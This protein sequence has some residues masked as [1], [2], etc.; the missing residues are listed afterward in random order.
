M[1]DQ[2]DR[3]EQD[4][5]N[6][7]EI[8]KILEDVFKSMNFSGSNDPQKTAAAPQKTA[9]APQKTATAPQKTAT[10]PQKT[11]AAP[12]K[13]ALAPEKTAAAPE[14][15]AK[16]QEKASPGSQ[17]PKQGILPPGQIIT[18]G[19]R[20]LTIRRHLSSGGEGE[21]YL[22]TDSRKEYT[23]KLFHPGCRT[24]SKIL[25]PL[26]Q[27]NGKGFIADII[28]FSEDYELT[29][30]IPGGDAASAS[31]KGNAQAILAI[32]VKTAAAL[33][34]LHKLN[35]L[36]KDIKPANILIKNTTTWD[37]VLCD[38]GISELL[39]IDG[40]CTTVQGRTPIYA[41][42][43]IYTATVTLPSGVFVELSTKSDFYS[44]G[45]SILS[46]W[47]GEKAFR[48]QESQMAMD[49]VKG[50]IQVPSDMP[51]PLARI[52]RGL[53]IKNPAKRWDYPEIERTLNGE[54]VPVEEDEIIED[55]NITFSAS[56]HLVA[57]SPEELADCMIEDPDLAKKY[58]YRGQLEKW[59]KP[60]PE[61]VLEM[62]EITEKRY[63]KDQDTGMMA[64]IYTLN[65][66]LPIKLEGVSRKD[67]KPL[68]RTVFSFKDV[69]NFCNDAIP[70]KESWN[71]L[72]SDIFLE[73]VRSK[74]KS[75]ADKLP[76]SKD[77][78]EV[79][80][81][82]VQMLDPLS[83]LNLI[84]DPSDGLYAMT[85]ESL[86]RL[87]NEIYSVVWSKYHGDLNKM[88]EDYINDDR[89][90]RIMPVT[91]FCVAASIQHPDY[92]TYLGDALRTKGERFTSQ[93]SW[94]KYCTDY[95][96]ADNK[97][98][99]G[100]KDEY[101]R[102]QAAWMKIIKGFGYTP[103]YKFAGSGKTVTTVSELFRQPKSTIRNAYENHGLA[104]WLAVQHHENPNADLSKQFA[105]ERLLKDYLED[106]RRIDDK[107]TY[108]TRFDRARNQV[109]SMVSSARSRIR[110]LNTS[111]T[112]QLVCTVL[113]AIIP[114]IILVIMLIMAIVQY[115]L[116]DTSGLA[117]QKFFWPVG[118]LV[119]AIV[120][121]T[122]DDSNGCIVPV[123]AGAIVAAALSFVVWL[124]GKFILYIFLAVVLGLGGYLSWKIL[125][126]GKSSQ[127]ARKLSK[128]GFDELV[129]EPLYYAFSDEY[130]FDSSLSLELDET[131]LNGWKADLKKR[132]I[133]VI[134]F[135]AS[136]WVLVG[137]STFVPNSWMHDKVAV[138]VIEQV[139]AP[140]MEQAAGK[141]V[142]KENNDLIKAQSLNPGDKGEEVR[143]LQKFLISTG[144]LKSAADGEYGANTRLAVRT[145]QRANGIKVTGKADKKT[146]RKIN[147]LAA[148]EG[149]TAK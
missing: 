121:F 32:A 76:A 8:G 34:R 102:A 38:F 89:S 115:P 14:K 99:A 64:A 23:L 77:D 27:L 105:Y 141:A 107:N 43:E 97:K 53:L 13:T 25:S 7:E 45:M 91:V 42:P 73:W 109:D 120:F 122:D 135:I 112:L 48:S 118:L 1:A 129:L 85:G 149:K 101:Y 59:L 68:S 86:G 46:M 41:A 128:P 98:K 19:S 24:R 60:Y 147:E 69:G 75:L 35:I 44:L 55:L 113:F 136:V 9:T 10:A 87:L 140:M 138:P 65:P 33:D 83:D 11:A 40:K 70:S 22:V 20:K 131:A 6:S 28:D 5:P 126:S 143:K 123:I 88:S 103:E 4:I 18:A 37:S 142:Q 56:K 3:K 39:D 72:D 148:R 104:G 67:R 79:A 95:D 29:E 111:N 50:R 66:S 82:R 58:L 119:A 21:L 84:N 132:R 78:I 52:C 31:L 90:L 114:A 125:K 133:Y 93:I 130:E 71:L 110:A 134:V 145:F 49:K 2:N 54:D 36:H 106:L 74:D 30:Y 96:S 57:H 144:H 26:Q 17:P 92:S 124:L 100:P 139:A 146:I 51:D 63:P 108:V 137:L 81:V 116:V 16:A 15:T 62:Q 61:L 127:K 80:M 47:M 94:I 117:L 12:E